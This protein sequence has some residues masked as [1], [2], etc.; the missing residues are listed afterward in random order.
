MP[1]DCAAAP[2]VEHHL[3]ESSELV[4]FVLSSFK[5]PGTDFEQGG[6]TLWVDVEAICD[7]ILIRSQRAEP[8]PQSVGPGEP[9]ERRFVHFEIL[10]ISCDK[11][12]S[13][14]Y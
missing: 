8:Q 10:A 3:D 1:R 7:Q 6:D 9:V 14:C 11:G 5:L 4:V 13:S 2:E 12:L